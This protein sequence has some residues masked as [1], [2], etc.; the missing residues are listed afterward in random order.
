[1]DISELELHDANLLGVTLA[2]VAGRAE[3]RLAYYTREQAP[4]RV[5]GTLVFD[6]VTQFNQLADLELL[7]EHAKFGNVS[8]WVSGELPGVSYLYLARG[9][10]AVTAASVELVAGA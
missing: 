5:L 2:P 9:L 8:Q 3:I 4:G 1:M 7:Q 10:I 6:G